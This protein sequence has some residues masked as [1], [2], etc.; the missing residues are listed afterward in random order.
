MLG[1]TTI[2]GRT[3]AARTPAKI[4]GKASGSSTCQRTCPPFI[5]MPG[6]RVW[7]RGLMFLKP[8]PPEPF[9]KIPLVWERAFGGMDES[10]DPPECEPRNPVGCGFRA[11]KSKLAAEEGRVPNLE[12]PKNGMR[13]TNSR[14]EPVGFG[15]IGPHWQPRV[16]HAGTYDEAWMKNRAPLLPADF[17]P[18]FFQTAPSDQILETL[19]DGN[20]PVEVDHASPSGKLAFTLPRPQLEAKA[21]FGTAY[22][23]LAMK[24]DTIV[25]DGDG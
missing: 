16:Q 12:S 21:R 11:K 19:P 13:G 5:P 14:P 3:A 9:E 2:P 18:R 23:S 17:N 22:E 24:L 10:V 20:I 8:S 7:E 1:S 6:E 4:T 15:F 25:F